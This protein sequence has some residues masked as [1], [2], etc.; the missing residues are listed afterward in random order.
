MPMPSP[1]NAE[2]ELREK[3]WTAL[4]QSGTNYAE[5]RSALD[6]V[7][8]VLLDKASNLLNAANIQEV[9]ETPRSIEG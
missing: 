7:R 3:L 2:M 6:Y 8:A 1:S 5:A 9:A 4:S